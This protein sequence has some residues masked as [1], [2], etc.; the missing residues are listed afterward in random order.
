M[1]LRSQMI[2]IAFGAWELITLMLL[3]LLNNLSYE[4]VFVLDLLGLLVIVQLV[5]PYVI[6]PKWRSNLN[7][8]LLVGVAIF[9]VLVLMKAEHVFGLKLL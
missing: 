9:S 5:S 8:F 3:A 1:L 7:I 4:Y 2:L 6:K